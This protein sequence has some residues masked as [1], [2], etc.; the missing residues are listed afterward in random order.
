MD[1]RGCGL[2]IERAQRKKLKTCKLRV[3]SAAKMFFGSLGVILRI[4]KQMGEFDT[5]RLAC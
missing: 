4:N 1:F 5:T 3:A 2:P